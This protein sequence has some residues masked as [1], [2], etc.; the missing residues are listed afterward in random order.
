MRWLG[1]WI[2]IALLVGS[3]ASAALTQ[4][5]QDDFNGVKDAWAQG[6]PALGGPGGGS[7]GFL[8][9][10]AD[11]VTQNGK[12]VTFNQLQWAGS[13]TAAGIEAIGMF[14]ENLGD[15]DLQM[16]VVLG[17]ISAP[18]SGGTW[19]ASTVPVSL[20]AGSGWHFFVFPLGSA[21]L[22]RT[23]GTADYATV[24][25]GVVTLRILN[26]A[27]PSAFG[28]NIVATAGVDRIVALP[29]PGAASL[30]ASG[31]VALALCARLRA[32]RQPAG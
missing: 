17:N 21:D 19:F 16:R 13:Y 29:E 6:T 10:H 14:L 22:T 18:S 27:V 31:V 28:D 11:G 3:A 12:L 24:M 1:A 9:L 32:R 23:Q 20:L 30:V 15:T 7:D 5:Q 25:N 26:S 2:T 4:G 8:L